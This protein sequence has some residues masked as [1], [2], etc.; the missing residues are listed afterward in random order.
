MAGGQQLA[1]PVPTGQRRCRPFEG[2]GSLRRLRSQ[3]AARQRCSLSSLILSARS[4]GW[5]SPTAVVFL[6]CKRRPFRS[7]SYIEG[8]IFG[9]SG[10]SAKAGVQRPKTFGPIGDDIGVREL[11]AG[12]SF[13]TG[14]G[15]RADRGSGTAPRGTLED[16]ILLEGA[17]S[18]IARLRSHVP[19]ILK[20]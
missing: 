10:R 3:P 18:Q 11:I 2:V 17:L 16:A 20:Y 7:W 9:R 6:R 4:P 13:T 1:H 5:Q 19:A 15:G 14:G 8:T 12:W